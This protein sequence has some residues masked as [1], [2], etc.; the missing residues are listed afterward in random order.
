MRLVED[1]E[2]T[3][4]EA[5][6]FAL[7]FELYADTELASPLE[8]VLPD[9][10]TTAFLSLSLIAAVLY[11][12]LRRRVQS[13]PRA[14]PALSAAQ[15]VAMIGAMQDSF[16]SAVVGL[17]RDVST[18]AIT[19]AEWQRRFLSEISS[20]YRAAAIIGFGSVDLPPDVDQMLRLQVLRQ[21]AFLGRFADHY[22]LSILNQNPWSAD[23]L[24]TRS[25]MY[26]G[27]LRAVGYRALEMQYEERVGWVVQYIAVD[28]DRTCSECIDAMANGPYMI[29]EGPFPGEVCLGRSR[30]RC[31]RE[32]VYDEAAYERLVS[33]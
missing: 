22:S 10:L 17:A 9:P 1:G 25:M 7:D 26:A 12:I 19:I 18:G 16:Q 33:R 13:I 8:N 29:G 2:I 14:I 27:A 3:E 24:A 5:E 23:Y 15:R 31:R 30:C 32:L 6:Q 21:T 11:A 4:V 20:S 28:D